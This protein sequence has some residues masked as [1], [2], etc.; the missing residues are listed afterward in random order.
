[1]DRFGFIHEKLDIKILILYVLKLLPSRV[2]F[3]QLTDLVMID[4]GFDYFEYTQCLAELVNTEHITQEG[5]YYIITPKGAEHCAEIQ[6]SIPYSVRSKA[7]ENAQ[8]LIEKMK[9]DALIGSSHKLM[10][11]GSCIVKLSLSDGMGS[12]LELSLLSSGEKQAEEMEKYF[13]RDA[14]SVYHKI[15]RILTPEL[16]KR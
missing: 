11:D 14:E 4:D 5:D 13:K 16:D 10:P 6:S 1:M 8:P 3:A 2:I 7:E 15:I 9:R 12:I